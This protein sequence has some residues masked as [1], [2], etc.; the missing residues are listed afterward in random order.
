MDIREL[1]SF[2]SLGTPTAPAAGTPSIYASQEE[3]KAYRAQQAADVVAASRVTNAASDVRSMDNEIASNSLDAAMRELASQVP[4]PSYYAGGDSS[5]PSAQSVAAAGA[6]RGFVNP[7][8]ANPNAEAPSS[9]QGQGFIDAAF[10]EAFRKQPPTG[11]VNTNGGVERV[12]ARTSE[13]GVTAVRDAKGNVTMTNLNPDGSVNKGTG[14]PNSVL[15]DGKGSRQ[16]AMVAP[17]TP[18]ALNASLE[19]LR[20]AT[21]DEARGLMA[22]INTSIA[23]AEAAL[24]AEALKFG[25]N[26]FGVAAL[27]QQLIETQAADRN[28]YGWYP[29]IG[30]SPVTQKVR[31]QIDQANTAA[32][33]AANEYLK[34]NVN[35][36]ALTSAKE[37]AATAFK[38]IE[39]LERNAENLQANLTIRSMEKKALKEENAAEIAS[40]LSTTAMNR[41]AIL[42][43]T[44]K[45]NTGEA[46]QWYE[47][48]F[49]ATKGEIDKVLNSTGAELV[50]HAM[51]RN[52][53]A[54]AIIAAEETKNDPTQTAE[55][56][57]M[58]L[59]KIKQIADSPDFAKKAA[60]FKASGLT[61]DAKKRAEQEFNQALSLG[62]TSLGTDKKE[63]T[64]QRYEIAL[65]MERAAQTDAVV[66]DMRHIFSQ[67]GPMGAAIA[68]AMKVTNGAALP[69]VLTAFIGSADS[70]TRLARVSMFADFTEKAVMKQ[71]ASVFGMPDTNKLKAEIIN[72]FRRRPGSVQAMDMIPNNI[73]PIIPFAKGV[74][75]DITQVNR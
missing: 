18:L 71:G 66:T 32:R 63:A 46:G 37:N 26:K 75:N 20:T 7:A 50:V 70:A 30:D 29:G 39:R 9:V 4:T 38:R 16:T 41:I 14:S 17:N 69:D 28:S 36:A 12:N 24:T 22:D 44:S 54:L 2:P 57:N 10:P 34:T 61:G 42:H 56:I 8:N 52:A 19:R 1:L 68:E 64:R 31:A 74:L 51:E 60:V 13:H 53:D 23:Q 72:T 58:R 62:K 3:W 48:R 15:G 49:K 27:E 65:E 43:P 35:V 55:K 40:N 6:G 33:A 67:D 73:S 11:V 25:A 45:G 5:S 21:P 59:S 47:Q